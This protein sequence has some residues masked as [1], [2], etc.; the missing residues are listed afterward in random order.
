MDVEMFLVYHNYCVFVPVCNGVLLPR[1]QI[2][3]CCC[4]FSV[5]CIPEGIQ[6][7]LATF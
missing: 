5:L 2:E 3:V 7:L 6:R 1:C 4:N